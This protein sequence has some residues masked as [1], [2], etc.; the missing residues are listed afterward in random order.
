MATGSSHPSRQREW[1]VGISVFILAAIVSAGAIGYLEKMRTEAIHYRINELA[2]EN[3]FRLNKEIDQIMALGYP[4]A[5][6][7][8]EDGTIDDFDFIA[9]KLIAHY[10]LIS[11]IAL[12]PGGII[13]RV[14]PLRGNEKAV[15]FNLFADPE[16][17]AEALLARKSGKLT[18]A[19]PLR[20]VQG[21]EGVVGRLPLFRGEEKK[22]WGFVFIVIRFPDILHADTL[23]N[24]TRHG[25][26]YTL[27]RIHPNTQQE[28][29]IAAS[30]HQRLDR[31]VEKIIELPNARWTLRIAPAD[32]WQNRPLL[33]LE[34]A[35]GI[36]FSVLLGYIA[37]Q[38]AELRNY[39]HFLEKRVEERTAEIA[40]T[41]NQ[42]RTLLDT[43]PD[44]IWLKNSDGIY[45]LCNPMFERFFGAAEEEIIG[46]SDYD[47]VDRELADFF[48]RKDLLAMEADGPSINE[49]WITFADDGHRALLET[50]K[51]PMVGNDRR[52]IGILGVARDVTERHLDEMRIKQLTRI[53]ATL[54]QCNQAIIHSSTPG[55]LFEKI[56]ENIVTIGGISMA[57][58]GLIDPKSGR[59]L[60]AASFGDEKHYLDG[61][62]ISTLDD[63]PEGRGPTGTAVRENRP[64]WCQDFMNDPS[65][66][67]WRERGKA[68]G[69]KSSAALPF[70]QNGEV[71]G[72]FTLYSTATDAFD[73][74]S[75]KLFLEMA[76]EI[77]FAMDNFEREAKRQ[78]AEA[79]L[80]HT[81]KLLEEMSEMAH[82]GG[83]EFDPESGVGSWT[84]ET[85]RIHGMDSGGA[86]AV[87]QG[88][89][90]YEGEWLGKVKSALEDAV[91]KAL[92]YDLELQMTTPAGEKK[93]VRTI[94]I[95]V[96]EHGKVIRV[97]GSMQDITAQKSA[98]E[99][100]HWLAHFDPLTK[101]PNR[102]LLNDRVDYALRI[103]H[104]SQ[105][106]AALLYLDL[107]HF[108]N[109]NETL[110][111]HIGDELIVQVA[112]R[113]GTLIREADT[114][115]RQGGDEFMIFLS[116]TDGDGAA[117]VAEKL[118][119]SVSQPYRIQHHE[120][121]ITPSIGIALYPT[122]GADLTALSQ[123]ADAAMYR[124][125]ENGRN[126]YRFFTPEIQARAARNLELENALRH[127]LSRNELELYYQP[128]ISLETGGLVGAE[129]LLRW[130]HPTLGMVS[131]SEFIPIAEESG[132]IIAIGEWVLRRALGQLQSWLEG[133]MEPF[134]M[135]V[136]LSAIQFRHP[137]LV[138]LVLEILEE[139]QL[140]ARYLELELT[141]RIASE[142]PLQAIA[143]MNELY[144]HGIR[145]SIDDFGTGYSSLNYLK[146]F[147]VY[148]LKIDQ[149]FIRDITDNPEDRTIVNAIINM[150]HSLS[151]ITIAEGVE[152]AGQLE[153]LRQSGC[154]EI[155]GYHFSK[156]LPADMF[157]RFV[158]SQ[159]NGATDTA[160]KTRT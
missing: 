102:T 137:K 53:Y 103:A 110:G 37:K 105:D 67:P 140:P 70:H 114:L 134:I 26:R 100:I 22:F 154:S 7:V 13:E 74:M 99:K 86:V 138:S 59:L 81:E 60:P 119:A 11:E 136:N 29:I 42:L 146:K 127:A 41:K 89:S 90:V 78:T 128:Q 92:P 88:L 80:L 32:G 12:A 20:L 19:G 50:I 24:L 150:A 6:T 4:I 49:E 62:A 142:N 151:M 156:P 104:R 84:S 23:A 27:T 158:H 122:D 57:W 79:D 71:I 96:V 123:S 75:R 132:Q 157:E 113:I 34:T 108:K 36:L 153:L 159:E 30:D 61:I 33:A 124:A 94:G 69:W 106:S 15:G 147:R 28:Q 56:C 47:F 87:T 133:G 155:Q 40:E 77:S 160:L 65:T 55:E 48:R 83:W 143:I 21:G 44:P 118:I 109:I 148:K 121:S 82:V 8:R 9:E 76:M 126:C 120:L 31:P 5:S 51:I 38:Y 144:D 46:R 72:A 54:S 2:G 64:V 1:G 115:S 91:D 63:I 149:S 101:L 73:P 18:L 141:E 107:D 97:R 35:L 43:I 131:P 145:M 52:L 111:H 85:A 116:G 117:H 39:R 93:W 139:V 25:Y 68:M 125:K 152:T 95:P 66:L 135:A 10:P 16:Q 98:E 3:I 14:V 129:A 58:I 112:S 130:N 45:L 17:Q